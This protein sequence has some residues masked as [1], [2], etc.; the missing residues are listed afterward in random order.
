MDVL[1]PFDARDPKTRLGPLL[2]ADE[3]RSVART[4]LED[5]LDALDAAGYEPT[6]LATDDVDCEAPVTVDDRPLTPAVNDVLSG[7]GG[8]VA[9]V[10]ADL[11]LLTPAALE[12]LFEPGADVVLAPGLGGGTNALVSRHPDFR[13][14]YHG[15]SYRD[16]REAARN[17]GAAVTTVDSFRLA[18]DVD[19]PPDLAEVLIH[20]AGATAGHLR[21]QGVELAVEGG[22]VAVSRSGE[23]S[24]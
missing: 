18:V 24:G 15:V 13:V 12:G 19:D 10:M 5:V 17:V 22:R 1:V 2:D 20:G 23:K 7:A 3:R 9:V 11:A 14:D 6:V 8:P 16:H 4:M 21:E